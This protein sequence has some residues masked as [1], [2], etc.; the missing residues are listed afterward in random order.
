MQAHGGITYPQDADGWIGFDA[1]HMGDVVP[2][3]FTW[4]G[5]SNAV[6]FSFVST[7]IELYAITKTLKELDT[8]R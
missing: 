2:G 3:V 8:K 4:T 7:V 6:Y 5:M 1:A